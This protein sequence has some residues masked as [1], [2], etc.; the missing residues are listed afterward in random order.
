MSINPDELINIEGMGGITP[1]ERPVAGQSLTND[2]DSKYPWEKPPEFTEVQGAIMSILADSYEKETYEMIA[3]SIADGMPVGD[4]TSMI[5]QA[6]FQEGKWNPDLMLMLI[7][8]TMYILAS[9]AEQCDIDYLLYRGDSLESYDNE[10]EEE[11]EEKELEVLKKIK[12]EGEDKLNFKDVK[13]KKITAESV[14]EKALEV[15]EDFEPPK[16][17]VSLLAR[18]KEE[19]NNSLLERT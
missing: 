2:P 10:N 11:T 9:I 18:K 8:P 15:I 7:E 17:L 3:L 4:L 19:S 16:E 13:I 6:G 12:Q 1:F 5:L 14:P